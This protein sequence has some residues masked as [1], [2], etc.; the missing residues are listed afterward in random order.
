[1]SP[2]ARHFGQKKTRQCYNPGWDC[3]AGDETRAVGIPVVPGSSQATTPHQYWVVGL[4]G[5]HLTDHR[6]TTPFWTTSFLGAPAA[7]QKPLY[8][9]PIANTGPRLGPVRPAAVQE[10]K[11]QGLYVPDRITSARHYTPKPPSGLGWV[12]RG[13][14]PN[15][16]PS[17]RICQTQYLIVR[18]VKNSKCPN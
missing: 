16:S 11:C 12:G 18:S 4:G 15:L 10:A 2:L 6:S 9:E 17:V 14:C 7:G 8:Q 1:M 5:H 3:P 13:C